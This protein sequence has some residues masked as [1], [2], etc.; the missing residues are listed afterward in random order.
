[1]NRYLFI[2]F[3]VSIQSVCAQ[4]P[5]HKKVSSPKLVIG[6][7]VDQMR[8]DF[9]YR[10]QSRYSPTGGFNRLLKQGF[11]FD[12]TMIPYMPTITGCGHAS[13]FT[14][15]V[16]AIHGIT[17]NNW[18]DRKEKREVYCSEDKSVQSVGSANASGQMSPKNLWVTTIGDELKL[19]TNFS[20]KV[21]GIALKDRGSILPAGHSADAAY[22]FDN[23]SGNWITS[24]YYNE[25]LPDWVQKIN[26]QKLVDQ[27]Y[28]KGWSTLDPIEKYN[29]STSDIHSY[30]AAPFGKDQKGFPY[31]LKRFIGQNYEA[32]L[33]TPF[34]NTLTFEF[35]KAAI[36]AEELGRDDITDLLTLSFSSPDY[37]GHAFGPNSIEIEDTYIRMDQDLGLFLNDLD[38]KIG[39]GQ[40][41]VFL[42]ADHGVAHVPGF[43]N[44]H[45]IPAGVFDDRVWMDSLNHFLKNKYDAFPLI[46][47]ILNYQVVLNHDLLDSNKISKESV[48]KEAIQFLSDLPGVHRVIELE[49]MDELPLQQLIKTRMVNGW[50]PSRSG[51]LQILLRSGWIDGSNTGTTHGVWNPYD[52]H[53]PNLWYGWQIPKG[54]SSEPVEMTDIAVTL[55]AL[56]Q[57]QMPSGAIGKSLLPLMKR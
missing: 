29:Q 33:R 18:W 15:T 9:L 23:K 24:S 54:R 2:L 5:K 38:K 49:D 14:G 13:I 22:W 26:D 1:M 47:K 52:S 42:T 20:S 45:K 10:Y 40:Y 34:G 36:A 8:W 27:Y 32:I 41:L 7:V 4:A 57:I 39:K 55:S 53:I 11:S 25:E 46:T 19:A 17:G 48:S 21:V 44:Q 16:P 56:L 31:D 43:L 51:D 3:F 6:I 12:Q 28:Q 37:I 35:A 30:E 50:H